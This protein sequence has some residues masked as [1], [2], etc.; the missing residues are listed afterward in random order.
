MQIH[1]QQVSGR[2]AE[3]KIPFCIVVFE[4]ARVVHSTVFR[5][6]WY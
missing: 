6:D 5:A 3:G 4:T 2:Q 1:V